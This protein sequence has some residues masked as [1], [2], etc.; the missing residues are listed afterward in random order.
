MGPHFL[1]FE[2][3]WESNPVIQVIAT[4]FTELSVTEEA[5]ASSLAFKMSAG[6]KLVR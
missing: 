6:Q 2:V 3:C 1:G 5:K 4:P